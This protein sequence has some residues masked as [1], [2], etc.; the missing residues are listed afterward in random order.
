MKVFFILLAVLALQLS[1]VPFTSG[2][3]TADV[4]PFFIQADG[5]WRLR[6][7]GPDLFVSVDSGVVANSFIRN[8]GDLGGWYVGAAPFV[9]PGPGP[10]TQGTATVGAISTNHFYVSLN[11]FGQIWGGTLQLYQDGQMTTLLESV[12]LEGWMT[13]ETLVKTPDLWT[14][15]AFFGENPVPEPATSVLLSIG[16]A[17]LVIAGHRKGWHL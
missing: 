16:L 9:G 3:L 17:G 13:S 12:T 11:S 15:T 2:L 1:G 8:N 14:R 10:L 5:G 4:D 7:T 6:L